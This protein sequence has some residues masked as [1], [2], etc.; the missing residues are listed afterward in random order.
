MSDLHGC[1]RLTKYLDYRWKADRN[2][3]NEV[4]RDW[5]RGHS[6]GHPYICMYVARHARNTDLVRGCKEI[7]MGTEVHEVHE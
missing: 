6:R 2:E 5:T 3:I 1:T 4:S 7:K